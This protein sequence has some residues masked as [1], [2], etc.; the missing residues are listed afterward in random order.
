MKFK[1]HFKVKNKASTA[2]ASVNKILSLKCLKL[3]YIIFIK[4]EYIMSADCYLDMRLN[5][6]EDC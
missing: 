5:K 4:T 3:R 1:A 2:G 6:T